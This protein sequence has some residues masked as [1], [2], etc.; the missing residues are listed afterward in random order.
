MHRRS[1]RIVFAVRLEGGLQP[2]RVDVVGMAFHPDQPLGQLVEPAAVGADVAEQR[3]RFRH[4]PRR[5]DDDRR[6][7]LHFLAELGHF[8][9]LD[10]RCRRL[11]LVDRVVHRSDQ[12]G[13]RASVERG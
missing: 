5:I 9:E 10:R 12:G 11:H 6:H 2:R 13:D 4:Q 7:V 8:I 1:A 3:H